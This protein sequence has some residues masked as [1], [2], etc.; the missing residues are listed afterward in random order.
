MTYSKIVSQ[1]TKLLVQSEELSSGSKDED[2]QMTFK[3]VSYK[4][5]R[6]RDKAVLG[7]AKTTQAGL[8]GRGRFVSLFISRFDPVVD[9]EKVKSYVNETFSVN[10]K[11]DSL[12]TRY[13]SY[14]SFKVEGFCKDPAVF[15]EPENWPENVLVRR[16]FKPKQ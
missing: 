4:K 1:P 15:Y 12:K 16:F 3:T 5:Q 8:G 6:R 14:S 11:C 7:K 9:Q 13:D 10:F 2:D